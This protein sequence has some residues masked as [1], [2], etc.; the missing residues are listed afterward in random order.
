MNYLKKVFKPI[1]FTI[2]FI[3]ISLLIITL[4]NYFNILGYKLTIYLKFILGIIAFILGGF[5][6][7]IR[8]S[9]KGWLEGL[10]YSLII[11]IPIIIISIIIR[12]FEYKCLIF[13]SI[14]IISSVI[15]SMFGITK[16]KETS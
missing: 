5:Q 9:K 3:L 11:I 16:N 12:S 14:L 7:G 1:V 15:G 10:R 2:L 6:I 13:Y 8:S 4:L